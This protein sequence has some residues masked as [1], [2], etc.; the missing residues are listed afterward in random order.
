MRHHRKETDR[1]TDSCRKSGP[2]RSHITYKY[3]E[4]ISEYIKDSPCKHG[5]CRQS[6]VLVVPQICRKHLVKQEKRD[7]RLN[8]KHVLSRQS[9]RM[10]LGSEYDQQITVEKDNNQPDNRR[11]NH[12]T[13]YRCGKI[14]V[15]FLN[16][17]VRLSANRTEQNRSS[18]SH[19]KSETVDNIPDR[20][21]HCQS[22]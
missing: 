15:R 8:R 1:R 5:S 16:I 17:S 11:K 4:I 13:D 3:K 18:D 9:K 12:R 7:C 22:R 2:E 14:F 19:Q 10:V 6:R 21:H 20:G